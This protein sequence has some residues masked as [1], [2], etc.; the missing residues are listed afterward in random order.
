MYSRQTTDWDKLSLKMSTAVTIMT[1]FL[2]LD[3]VL[4]KES[5]AIKNAEE[6]LKNAKP[7]AKNTK[8][9]S[10]AKNSNS[11]LYSSNQMRARQAQRNIPQTKSRSFGN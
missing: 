10:V 11:L 5:N 1:F 2:I 6:K 4:P 3:E 8:Q 7:Q 9:V